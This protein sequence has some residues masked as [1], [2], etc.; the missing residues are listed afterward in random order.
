MINPYQLTPL[1]GL[2]W[3]KNGILHSPHPY[4]IFTPS[5]CCSGS[6]GDRRCSGSGGD[7]LHV[8]LAAS[9]RSWAQACFLASLGE[10]PPRR[11][12]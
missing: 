1:R 7:R 11:P 10:L 3:P 2:T 8:L 5:F 6:G 9:P 12:S 4:N